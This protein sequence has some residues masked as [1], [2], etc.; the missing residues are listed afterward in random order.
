MADVGKGIKERRHCRLYN[1]FDTKKQ[2]NW[3][4]GQNGGGEEEASTRGGSS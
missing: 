1:S 4:E 2:V 3:D